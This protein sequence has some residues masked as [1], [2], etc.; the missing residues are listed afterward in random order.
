MGM[1]MILN[2]KI[3]IVEDEI[4]VAADIKQQ[5]ENIGYNVIGIAFSGEDAI[6]KT[7]ETN[8]DIVLMDI[9]LRGNI[10]GIEAAQ[11]IRNQY[12]I[13][14]IYITGFF[15]DA[16]LERAKKTEPYGYILKPFENMGIESAI[17]MAVYNHKIWQRLKNTAKLM[18]YSKEMI[19]EINRY[20]NLKKI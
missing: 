9:M 2:S 14:V 11:Q 20:Y 15:D 10:D 12:D 18:N 4:I 5:L 19:K 8:P 17:E 7:E 13:P 16:T 6:R 1:I 3:F